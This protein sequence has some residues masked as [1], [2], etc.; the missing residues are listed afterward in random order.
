M[1]SLTMP[2]RALL[3]TCTFRRFVSAV[4]LLWVS[5]TTKNPTTV[6]GFATTGMLLSENFWSRIG[7]KASAHQIAREWQS[8]SLQ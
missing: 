7:A 5:G 6:N 1:W 4:Q 8:Y 2:L 3:L